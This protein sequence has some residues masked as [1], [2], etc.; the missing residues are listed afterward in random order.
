MRRRTASSTQRPT[1]GKRGPPGEVG[2][3]PQDDEA[4]G[5]GRGDPPRL[6]VVALLLVDGPH[7]RGVAAAH[8]VL[9][10]VE[11][12][13]GVGMGPFGEHEVVVR[14]EGIGAPCPFA[15]PDQAAVDRARRVGHRPFEQQLAL[16]ARGVMV[17]QGPEVVDLLAG[18]QVGGQE[19]RAPGLAHEVG[20]G[21][22]PRVATTQA[23]GERLQTWRRARP[24]SPGRAMDVGALAQ[25]LQVGVAE[26]GVVGHAQLGHGDDERRARRGVRLVA[27]GQRPHRRRGRGE[28]DDP[29]FRRGAQIDEGVGEHRDAGP[30]VVPGSTRWTTTTGSRDDGLARHADEDDIG[31]E[32]VVQL[33]EG[34]APGSQRRP[35][36][37]GPVA[38][39]HRCGRDV[40]D[41]ASGAEAVHLDGLDRAVAGDDQPGA[42]P[43]GVGQ[44]PGHR[45]SRLRS[46]PDRRAGAK[47]SRSKPSMPL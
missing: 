19:R 22:Y 34:V 40:T 9:V 23:G 27:G 35:G 28:L 42:G 29:R 43:E 16:G 17:L 14:L 30:V 15:D 6:E 47:A 24:G 46:P 36:S 32:G 7:R 8:V 25:H 37:R 26:V 10:D 20:V 21:A 2:E 3:E 1:P 5:H 13:H 12:G 45:Q 4:F 44:A 31:H 33:A 11:I 38:A 39:A 41:R 18:P